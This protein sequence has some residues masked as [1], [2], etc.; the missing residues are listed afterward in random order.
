MRTHAQHLALTAIFLGGCINIDLPSET[1]VQS[2]RI[3]A[4]VSEPP[5]F[6]PGQDLVMS[7]MVTDAEGSPIVGDEAGL[8]FRWS[9]CLDLQTLFGAADQPLPEEAESDGPR[10]RDEASGRIELQQGGD[11][12]VGFGRLPGAASQA[13]FD[14]LALLLPLLENADPLAAEA[15]EQLVDTVGL[16]IVIDFEIFEA[17]DDGSEERIAL[18]FKRVAIT[19]REDPTTN[20][21]EPR[22]EVGGVE[23]SAREVDTPF[24]CLPVEDPEDRPRVLAGERLEIVPEE[25]GLLS[26]VPEGEEPGLED[27]IE[28]YPVISLDGSIQI[29]EESAYYS[30]F[31]TAGGFA[32]GI[33][34]RP[35][36]NEVWTAPAD[37]G[38]YPLWIVVRDGHLGG[39]ACRFEVEVVAE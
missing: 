19:Q 34:Q 29:N 13:L 18:G 39:S 2:T 16:A 3:L 22:F 20:P 1:R 14:Q 8:R 4:I 23:L 10:C 33:T 17:R 36:R 25:E 26:E 24:V 7:A 9:V 32:E 37:P 31:G 27:W 5:E 38:V 6:A 28:T 30:Y 35:F 15:I 12:P 21:P 11:L